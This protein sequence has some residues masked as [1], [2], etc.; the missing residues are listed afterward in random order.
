MAPYL[1]IRPNITQHLNL[2]QHGCENLTANTL[3][4]KKIHD[5]SDVRVGGDDD[6]DHD[7]D[8]NDVKLKTYAT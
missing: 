5:C 6:H 2:H 4:S 1:L 3:S 8:N 7:N